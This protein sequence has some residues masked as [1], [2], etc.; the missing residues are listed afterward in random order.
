[1]G[2]DAPAQAIRAGV[3]ISG[4]TV[5]LVDRGVD[6][7]PVLAQA[8]VPVTPDDDAASLHARIQRYEHRLLPRVVDCI[9]RGVISLE[10]PY[11]R[12]LPSD[13]DAPLVAPRTERSG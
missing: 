10:P 1:P 13:L 11:V 12:D 8:A 5:H 3:R 6:T 9:A 7:G 4:C 2:V